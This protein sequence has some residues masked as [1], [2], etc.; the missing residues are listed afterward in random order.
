VSK[1]GD[2][3]YR[4]TIRNWEK[5]QREMR[6]GEKRKRRRE[7]VAISVDLF[8]DPDYLALDATHSRL[9]LGLL[10]HSGK[11]GP[12]FVLS[13]SYA[14][15]LFDLRRSCDFEVL[16]NHGFID[17]E[18]ATARAYKTNKTGQDKTGK[19]VAT[20]P[21]KPL[22]EEVEGLN[23]EAWNEW[24]AHRRATKKPAYKTNMKAIELATLTHEQQLACVRH[25]ISNE[26]VGLFPENFRGGSGP[27]KLTYSEKLAADM[28][29]KGMIE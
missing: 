22:V 5:Y 15:H 18:A 29:G 13:P 9:W 28:R 8:S 17:L 26:Y 25:S 20:L 27:K 6:G 23:I 10:L 12:S 3:K 2:Q 21:K 16:K 4:I 14:R 7:W 24:V 11:V 1:K 19:K